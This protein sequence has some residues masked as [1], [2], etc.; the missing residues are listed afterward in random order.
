MNEESWGLG[1]AVVLERVFRTFF[2]NTALLCIM[3]ISP[4]MEE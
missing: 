4:A 1:W 2:H 3:T